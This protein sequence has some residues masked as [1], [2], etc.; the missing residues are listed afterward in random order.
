[1]RDKKM[2]IYIHIAYSEFIQLVVQVIYKYVGKKISY[3]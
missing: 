3:I 1:M 2:Y